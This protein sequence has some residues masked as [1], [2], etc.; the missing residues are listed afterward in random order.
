MT[1]VYNCIMI[2]TNERK[3]SKMKFGELEKLE[4][5]TLLKIK[6]NG[7]FGKVDRLIYFDRECL[8]TSKTSSI[9]K[10]Y[11][12]GST[13]YPVEWIKLATKNDFNKAI[14]KAEED[15]QRHINHLKDGF[16]KSKKVAKELKN[17]NN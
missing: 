4:N 13:L 5:G 11:M 3:Q 10:G 8:Y 2:N 16:E 7:F 15:Y 12:L 14:T 9:G 6:G 17:E 1:H